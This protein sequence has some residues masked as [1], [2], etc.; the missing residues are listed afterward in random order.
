MFQKHQIALFQII[1]GGLKTNNNNNNNSS[2]NNKTKKVIC[3]QI[4]IRFEKKENSGS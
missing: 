3:E 1:G 2:N 4:V